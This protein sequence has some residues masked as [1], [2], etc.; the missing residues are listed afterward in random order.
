MLSEQIFE[1]HEI[2]VGMR[3]REEFA[4]SRS[5]FGLV[6]WVDRSR[7]LPA[8]P[9]SSNELASADADWVLDNNR[10]LEALEARIRERLTGQ[11]KNFL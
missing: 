10:D 1:D 8:E 6:I 4:R 3:S 9:S 11:Q 2:Y 7:V 5:L